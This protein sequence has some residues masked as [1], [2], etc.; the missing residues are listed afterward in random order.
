MGDS[1]TDGTEW[2]VHLLTELWES[3]KSFR[4][5][6][7][8]RSHHTIE[9]LCGQAFT[10]D[11]INGLLNPQ[12]DHAAMQ[13]LRF[14]FE[15]ASAGGGENASFVP[16]ASA[17]LT[18]GDVHD[19]AFKTVIVAFHNLLRNGSKDVKYSAVKAF[20]RFTENG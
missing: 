1:P 19:E 7:T 8:T 17:Q 15:Q 9:E 20:Y 5:T 16:D 18:V 6:T 4:S 2:A 11:T 12:N 3:S 10:P 13:A 14:F